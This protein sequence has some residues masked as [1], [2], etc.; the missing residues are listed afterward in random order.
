MATMRLLL[1]SLH[2]AIPIAAT[3]FCCSN[4]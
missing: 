4:T 2:G 3:Y 1:P